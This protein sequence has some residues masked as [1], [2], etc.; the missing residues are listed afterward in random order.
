MLYGPAEKMYK[1]LLERGYDENKITFVVEEAFAHN[2]GA[3]RVIYPEM[4]DFLLEL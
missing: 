2:E 4:L 1:E 3:W